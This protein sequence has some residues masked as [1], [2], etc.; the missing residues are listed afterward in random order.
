MSISWTWN[1]AGQISTLINLAVGHHKHED[2][3]KDKKKF[4]ETSKFEDGHGNE[5]E[6]TIHELF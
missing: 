1:Q 3:D 5:E 6:R 2:K 4:K